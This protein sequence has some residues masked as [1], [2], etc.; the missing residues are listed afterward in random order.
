MR[1]KY[2]SIKEAVSQIMQEVFAEDQIK[3][4]EKQI[5]QGILSPRFES[6][7]GH[8][9]MKL[10]EQCRSLAN[11]PEASYDDLRNFVEQVNAK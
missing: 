5:L 9:F 4:A 3:T 10:S 2:P 1:T 8:Y 7:I 11:N 6:D